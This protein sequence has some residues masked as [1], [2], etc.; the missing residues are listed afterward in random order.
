[1]IIISPVK[2]PVIKMVIIPVSTGKVIIVIKMPESFYLA[3][4]ISRPVKVAAHV[5]TMFTYF[6][7]ASVSPVIIPVFAR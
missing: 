5:W 6:K 2:I 1:M 3:A 7:P 4:F